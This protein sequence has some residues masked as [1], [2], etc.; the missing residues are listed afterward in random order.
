MATT[1][2]TRA[3]PREDGHLYLRPGEYGIDPVD[4]QW[5][6]RLPNGQTGM[7]D[8]HTVTEHPDGTITVSPSI[9]GENWHG[10][11]VGGVWREC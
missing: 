8:G 2:G 7:L 5:T 9:V 4:G 10:Y 3:H 11:L 1:P 6:L